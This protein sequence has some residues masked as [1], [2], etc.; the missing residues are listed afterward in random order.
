MNPQLIAQLLAMKQADVDTRSRL[1]S[2]GNLYGVYASEMQQLHRENAVQLD[3][4]V[5]Q[6]GWP[7][8]KLV[9]MEGCRAAWLIAQHA[10]CTPDLQRKFLTLLAKASVAADAPR[11]QVAFLTD[12][13]RFN[14]CR[15]QVYGTIF[16]WNES[17]E[18]T[19]EVDDPVN[20]ELRRKVVGL[21][22]FHEELKK[23]KQE[24]DEEGGRPPADYNQYKLKAREWAIEVGWLQLV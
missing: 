16:D 23:H 6:Y 11:A 1:L 20:L 21:P 17:G 7:G 13:I 19:C 8:M 2:E 4:I 12:R 18:L 15:P 3:A 22:P 24:V 14:E 10:I 5:E 9:G